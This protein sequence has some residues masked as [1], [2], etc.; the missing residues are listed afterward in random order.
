MKV[1]CRTSEP[2]GSI[3]EM[4]QHTPFAVRNAIRPLGPGNVAC[5]AP[6]RA[7]SPRVVNDRVTSTISRLMGSPFEWCSPLNR[8]RPEEL[9]P[10][11]RSPGSTVARVVPRPQVRAENHVRGHETRTSRGP[12]NGTMAGGRLGPMRPDREFVQFDRIEQLRAYEYVAEQ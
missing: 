3:V 12:R 10:L 9:P 1:S 8:T 4:L 7:T 6:P 5:A 11:P 2:S